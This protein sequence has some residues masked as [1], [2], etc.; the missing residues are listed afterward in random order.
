MRRKTVRR[1]ILLDPSN[2]PSFEQG[3][4]I[5]AVTMAWFEDWKPGEG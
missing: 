3:W 5:A 1:P 4:K 2:L